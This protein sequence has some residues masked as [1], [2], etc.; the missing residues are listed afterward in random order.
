MIELDIVT[1]TRRLVVGALSPKVKL[2]GAKGQLEILSGH[3]DLLTLLGVGILSYTE[4]GVEKKFAV[5]YGFAEV[6]Q[7]KLTVLAETCEPADEVDVERAQKAQ[8]KAEVALAGSL[9]QEEFQK[10]QLKVQ[11][12]LIRQQVNR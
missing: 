11:R 12:A 10:Y 6:R 3:S 4:D 7:N 1:P 5:S 2:P 9:T 8:K